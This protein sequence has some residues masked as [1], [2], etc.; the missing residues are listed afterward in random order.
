MNTKITLSADINRNK[1]YLLFLELCRNDEVTVDKIAH[2]G[3]KMMKKAKIHPHFFG[4]RSLLDNARY[5]TFFSLKLPYDYKNQAYLKRKISENDAVVILKLFERRI[6]E[7][8]PVEYLTQ[9]TFYLGRK[10]FVNENVLIPRSVMNTQF[11]DFLRQMQWE[12]YRVLD[13]C[14]GSGCIGISLALMEP[15]IKVDLADISGSALEVAQININNYALHER[16]KCI[17]TDLFENI[18]DK[19]DLIITNPPYVSDYEYKHQPTEIK[20]EPA[21]ALKG[22]VDGLHI[23][24]EIILQSKEYLNPNGLLICEVGHACASLLKRKY[25]KHKFEWC[26]SKLFEGTEPLVD[27]FIRWLGLLDS[28]FICDAHKLPTTK[29]KDEI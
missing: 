5:L 9:E 21:L 14:A 1:T 24:N 6:T 2:F 22:G 19:Y 13:L 12:N 3:K 15:N 7:R 20:N 29:R 16:V 23:V 4:D 8:K 11:V 27:Q 17:Q 10:F 18:Q 25:R 28:F 26:K